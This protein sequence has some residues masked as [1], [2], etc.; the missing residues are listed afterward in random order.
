[1]AVRYFTDRF[2]AKL[3]IFGSDDVLLGSS[4]LTEA[5]LM[6]NREAVVHLEN[7]GDG[8]AIEEARVLFAE[9]WESAAVL[10]PAKLLDFKLALA[11]IDRRAP[12]P[13][14]VVTKAV[15]RCEPAN[16]RVESR[17]RTRQQVF[18]KDLEREVYEQYKPAFD[19]V[20]SILV[21]EGLSRGGFENVSLAIEANRFLN[22]VRLT[23]APGD[24]AWQQAA[25][26]PPAERA[27]EIRRLGGEWR[28]TAQHCIPPTYFASLANVQQVFGSAESIASASKGDLT[29]G[30]LG[31][32][33]FTEQLR[34]VKGG[35][36]ALPTA[37]WSANGDDL[38]KVRRSLGHLLHGPGDFIER[39]HDLL[40][41]ANRKLAYFGYFS[42]LE[43]YGT[44]KPNA[45]P[46]LNGRMAKALRYLG[47]DVRPR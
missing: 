46:P 21:R 38:A 37:F 40:Y 42:A 24:D 10:T 15:G 4:N 22:W 3:Y 35:W 47:Y 13:E 1:M 43:L 39:F 30:L 29:E 23:H 32:H 25:I 33:A 5:G 18:A 20:A 44:T 31:I 28:V 36:P 34:F 2:H 14:E 9:L 27:A 6:L 26:R 7:P 11:S 8:E 45:L 12:S 41:V 17:G 16:V 19:D